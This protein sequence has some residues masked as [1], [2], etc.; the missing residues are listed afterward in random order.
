MG[1]R[2][3]WRRSSGP[4][5][6][7]PSGAISTSL[8]LVLYEAF[9]GRRAFEG[10]VAEGHRHRSPLELRGWHRLGTGAHQSC[11]VWRENRRSGLL[12][13]W[14]FVPHFQEAIRSL[15][16]SRAAKHRLPQ[17]WPRRGRSQGLSP[18]VAWTCL[19]S[20]LF[21][22]AGTLWIAGQSRLSQIVPLPESPAFLIADARSI[23]ED[24]GYPRPSA[25]APTASLAM[26]ATSMT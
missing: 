13:R 12:R 11:S 3:I 24:L 15:P 6:R 2:A 16:P 4:A 21:S 7:L 9:T 14:R 22:L 26:S 17:S 23:L 1:H 19:L 18:A 5:K 8:G 10:L 20:V 25:T